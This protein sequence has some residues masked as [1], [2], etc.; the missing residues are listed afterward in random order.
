MELDELSRTALVPF[1]AR[2]QDDREDSPILGDKAAAA[3]AD[4]AERRFGRIEVDLST[5]VGCC[6]RNWA[7][8]G[9]V[10]ALAAE[11][12]DASPT[13]IDIGV[14]LDTRLCRL[15]HVARRYIEVDS[16]PIVRLR[17]EWLPGTSAVRIAHDGMRVNDWADDA[18]DKGSLTIL[19]LEGVLAYQDPG[20]VN[21]FF[22][23]AALRWPGA[24]LLFDSLSPLSAWMANRWVAPGRPRYLWTTWST[25]RLRAD[26][27]RLRVRQ[28]SAFMDL[29]REL[30]RSFSIAKR[31]TY[32]VPPFR[33]SYRLT[34]ATLPDL[35]G[36]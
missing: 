23:E 32:L 29:P 12:R 16:E 26:G 36:R 27:N 11:H 30:T 34:L 1:W 8:D 5:Q 22:A 10:V 19:I 15:P 4:M 14:G 35:V 17:D 21:R 9:W 13:I 2:V 31:L 3:L 24:Y 18:G 20:I 28:E 6:L 7:V 33:R 25:K